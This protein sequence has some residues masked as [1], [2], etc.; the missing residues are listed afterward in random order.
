MTFQDESIIVNT[1][2]EK[3]P[4]VL[5]ARFKGHLATERAGYNGDCR[6]L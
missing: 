3:K 6:K 2:R 1:E 5:F 4:C